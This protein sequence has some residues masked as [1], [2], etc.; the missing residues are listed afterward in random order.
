MELASANG[1]RL[2]F[3]GRRRTDPAAALLVRG[4][5][6]SR[7]VLSCAEGN[8]LLLENDRRG[9]LG[10]AVDRSLRP[11]GSRGRSMGIRCEGRPPAAAPEARD[12][13]FY[14]RRCVDLARRAVGCTSPNPMVGCVIVKGGEVVG[15]G[16]HPKAGQPHA[17]VK[18]SS[19]FSA[20]FL[21]IPCE[22]RTT[23]P[24]SF[25]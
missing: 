19:P 10:G 17:E 7:Q 13:A 20:R 6:F 16:F 3:P 4:D 25:S 1:G 22:S 2:L 5:L 14:M 8:S 12:D 11:S 21:G 24:P 23:L 15:E 9:V 18:F